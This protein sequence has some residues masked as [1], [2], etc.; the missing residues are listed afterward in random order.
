MADF[1]RDVISELKLNGCEFVRHGKG[2]HDIWKSPVSGRVFPV[3][4]K[5]RTRPMANKIMKDAGL[6]KRF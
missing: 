3:D 5:I 6:G 2:D 1:T 4:S